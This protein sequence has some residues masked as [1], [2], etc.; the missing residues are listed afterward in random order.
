MEELDV[1]K[2]DLKVNKKDVLVS[3]F[4][5]DLFKPKYQYMVLIIKYEKENCCTFAHLV[6]WTYWIE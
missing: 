1:G 5:K 4:G 2:K 3:D 6:F